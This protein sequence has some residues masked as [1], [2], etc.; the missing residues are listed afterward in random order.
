MYSP[1]FFQNSYMRVKSGEPLKCFTLEGVEQ[2]VSMRMANL[3]TLLIFWKSTVNGE[4]K[5]DIIKTLQEDFR[6]R[7]IEPQVNRYS[8]WCV[9]SPTNV[10]IANYGHFFSETAVLE[11]MAEIKAS[12]HGRDIGLC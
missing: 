5:K 9:S 3:V 4:S 8:V 11:I 10:M 12:L 7:L 6:F 2:V 1:K